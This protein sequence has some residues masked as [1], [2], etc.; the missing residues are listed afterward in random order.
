MNTDWRLINSEDRAR[1]FPKEWHHPPQ[2]LASG[3]KPGCFLKVG[4]ENTQTSAGERFWVQV[5]SIDGDVFHAVVNQDLVETHGLNDTDPIDV[6]FCNVFGILSAQG[7]A[8][9]ETPTAHIRQARAAGNM[10]GICHHHN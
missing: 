5:K 10:G 9:W 4:L 8:I 1:Q 6:Q 3:I 2:H 7:Q